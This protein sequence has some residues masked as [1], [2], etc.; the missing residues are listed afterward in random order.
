MDTDIFDDIMKEYFSI[1]GTV[2]MSDMLAACEAAYNLAL[3]TQSEPVAD[4]PCNDRVICV[5]ITKFFE[6]M[7]SEFNGTDDGCDVT[8]DDYTIEKGLR[9]YL[10]YYIKNKINI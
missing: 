6:S 4:V 8:L 3:T 5:A 7:V 10:D 1:Y 2:Y 9:P